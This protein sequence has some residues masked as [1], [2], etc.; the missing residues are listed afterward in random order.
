MPGFIVTCYTMFSSYLWDDC[1]F[2]KK[3]RSS[4]SGDP[5]GGEVGRDLEERRKANCD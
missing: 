4:G 1:S 3:M 2:L 5:R